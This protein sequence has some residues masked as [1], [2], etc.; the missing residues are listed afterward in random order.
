MTDSAS[1]Q[2]LDET[3][4]F[5]RRSIREDSSF[6]QLLKSKGVTDKNSIEDWDIIN[7]LLDSI[8]HSDPFYKKIFSSNENYWII[9]KD[10]NKRF[11]PLTFTEFENLR[12]DKRIDL[13]FKNEK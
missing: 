8:F 9:D 2:F 6:Y 3:T 11:G 10:E 1:K 7:P 5:I 4:P 13:K 12:R